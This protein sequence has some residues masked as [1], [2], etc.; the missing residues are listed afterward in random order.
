[1]RERARRRRRGQEAG[2][3]AAGPGIVADRLPQLDWRAVVNS[4]RPVDILDEDAIE[5]IHDASMTILEEIGM[6]FLSEEAREIAAKAGADVRPGSERVRFDR[7]LIAELIA[8]APSRFDFHA[9]NPAHDLA[10]GD[11]RLIFCMVASAPNASDL[12]GGRRRGNFADYQ[13]FLRLS[14]Q[15]NI[16]HLNGGYPVEP[17]DL[18]HRTRHLDALHAA[19]TLTDKPFHAY[20]LGRERIRDGIEIARLARGID[21][22]Q[23]KREPSL[24]TI[25]NTNSPLKLDIPMALGIIEMARM[26]QI[27]VITPFTLS[28]AMAPVTLAGAIAQQNAEALAGIAFA[29]MVNPGAPCVYGGFTSNVDMKSGAP[30]F[31]TPEYARAAQIGGQLAR[32]YGLP[33]RSSNV[34]ASNAPDVQSAYESEMAVWGAVTGGCNMMMHALGWL[35]GGLCASFEKVMIDAEILQMMAEYLRPIEVNDDTLG[36]EAIRDVGPGGHFFGT[37]HTLARYDRAFYAPML[38]DWR[39]FE[40]WQ[41]AGAEDATTRAHRL[42]KAHLA[43]YE[44]PPMDAA[45]RESL[46]AFVAR[47]KEEGG[48]PAD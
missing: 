11:G 27:V 12:E 35:E 33:F 6:D 30:A 4:Y 23:L 48:A 43:E 19:A 34:N 18:P 37:A 29:Q 13:D 46:D 32:R 16:C 38:S 20:S 24:F 21:A 9:R 41:E 39:N 8:K 15:L 1:M 22:E 26:N 40:T 17:I 36:L 47:R 31:G 2:A 42:Y 3:G 10:L 45:V 28:G 14:Q 25:I 5:R 44:A 7:N